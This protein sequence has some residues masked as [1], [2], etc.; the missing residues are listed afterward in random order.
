MDSNQLTILV[1][2]LC[3]ALVCVRALWAYLRGRDP[4]ERDVSLVFLA[5]AQFFVVDII[6]RLLGD[7]PLMVSNLALLGLLLQPFL[8][9]R[10]AARLR[11]MPRWL[12]A[13][14]LGAFL[15]TAGPTM[16]A[17][18]PRPPLLLA[19]AIVFVATELVAAGY[20]AREASR[21]TGPS[22]SRLAIAAWATALFAAAV[23]TLFAGPSAGPDVASLARILALLSAMGYLIAFL[24]PAWLR[25]AWAAKARDTASRH[26]LGGDVTA[27]AEDVWRRY[28]EV[29]RRL[30]GIEAVAVLMRPQPGPGTRDAA[31]A[32]TQPAYGGFAGVPPAGCTG[33][34]LDEL[35]RAH[36][37]VLLHSR[38]APVPRLVSHYAGQVTCRYISAHP[39][40]V[41]PGGLGALLLFHDHHSLF[42]DDD[43][44]LLADLGGQAGILAERGAVI[45]EQR[46]LGDELE[47]TVRALRAA[48]QAKSDFLA[49]MS[50]ELRTP[51]NAIIGFSDLMRGEPTVDGQRSAPADWVDHIHSSGRHL[52]GL[53]NDVLDLAKV[54]AGRLDLHPGLLRLDT[55]ADELITSLRPLLDA[56]GLVVT[57]DMPALIANVDPIRFRQMLEN[58]LS[59]AIKFTP[60]GGRI[61]VTGFSQAAKVMITVADTGVGIASVDHERVFE[62]FQQVGDP[63]QRMAGTGLGLAL[64]RR[65]AQAH[66]GDIQLESGLG[67]GSRFSICLPVATPV[68]VSGQAGA[69]GRGAAGR[70]A[71]GRVLLIEDDVRSVELLRTYLVEAGYHVEVAGTGEAGVAAARRAT[72]DAVLLDV[73]LPGIHGWEVLRQFKADPRLAA[74]PI[75]LCTVVDERRAGQALGA[76]G[77]FVK[78]VEHGELLGALA[79]HV[80]PPSGREAPSVLLVEPDDDARGRVERSLR[81][82]GATV[83]ICT[84]G[85]HGLELS[86]RQQ[87]DLIVCD[88]Q[89]PDFDG[90]ALLPAL[91]DDPANRQ[92][93]VLALTPGGGTDGGPVVAGKVHGTPVE[94]SAAW[95]SLV[96]L[97]GGPPVAAAPRANGTPD[98][99]LT[100]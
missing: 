72:P 36:Q 17:P 60:V 91:R 38:R 32:L 1:T 26:M 25:L 45:A 47:A 92:T 61:A 88:P 85:R 90:F 56:K 12:T 20:F 79:R 44:R 41:P 82:T 10:L 22:S 13:A 94:G 28:T 97:T 65:L 93:P 58:L 42:A 37:P 35:L 33:A 95:N 76:D 100:P 48:S 70:Q 99:E 77:Y 6:R 40:I 67:R 50:H 24:P 53:I 29:V 31:A 19:L 68:A 9:L 4:V 43:L 2:E 84:D 86:R 80:L 89:S 62:E 15:V 59:N 46:R 49:S 83:V 52:L 21:R 57:L 14:A 39:L 3:F 54:E 81:A 64:A 75:F 7:V 87:F 8:T 23:A 73:V 96:A 11:R 98:E 69:A 18:R 71:R 27:T 5:S 51:L 55:A 74:V 78:P 66:G 30:V 34:D 16:V 63:A